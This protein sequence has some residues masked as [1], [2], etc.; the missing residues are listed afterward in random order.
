MQKRS[1]AKILRKHCAQAMPGVKKCAADNFKADRWVDTPEFCSAKKIR[2]S[3]TRSRRPFQ[4]I[5]FMDMTRTR[6]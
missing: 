2:A 3:Q 6:D 1:S 4:V 5:S